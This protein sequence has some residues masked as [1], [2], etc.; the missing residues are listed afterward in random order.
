MASAAAGPPLVELQNDRTVW[1]VSHMP[2]RPV[3]E[4]VDFHRDTFREKKA[5]AAPKGAAPAVMNVVTAASSNA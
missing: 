2:Y 1:H 3:V 4:R 5:G